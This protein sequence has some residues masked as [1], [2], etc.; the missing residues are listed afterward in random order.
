MNQSLRESLDFI[1]Y[2]IEKGGPEEDEY[3]QLSKGFDTIFQNIK[4]GDL[5]YSDLPRYWQFYRKAFLTLN[6]MQGFVVLKPHGYPGDFEIIDRIYQKWFSPK[7]DLFRWDSYFHAQAAAKAVRNRK[8]YFINIISSLVNEKPDRKICVLNI[9][10]GPGRDLKELLDT[11]EMPNILIDCIDIDKKAID[12]A[13]KLNRKHIDK[14]NFIHKNILRFRP[15]KQY[16]I[17][18]SAGV[19]D[20]LSDKVFLY[21]LKRFKNWVKKDGN[22]IIG[23]FSENN[24]TRPYMEFGHWF[25]FHRS[26]EKLLNLAR[27]A[28]FD[29]RQIKVDK[30]P[31][32][33]N[34]FLWITF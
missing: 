19:F 34:L 28:N 8:E 30:E 20:Y 11:L 1:G 12:Y 33:I 6:T 3:A 29:N 18:W 16:D 14:L 4:Q 5:K 17:I 27:K 7:E 9:G 13:S 25:L 26:K 21:M 23:N 2:L 10:S 32:G 24:P 22:I 15:K 31:E